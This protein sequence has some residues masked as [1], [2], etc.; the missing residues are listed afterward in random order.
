MQDNQ[1]QAVLVAYLS[2]IIDG[3]GWIIVR[4]NRGRG[5]FYF[6]VGV[7]M[8]SKHIIE[9]LQETFGGNVYEERVPNRRSIWRWK[10]L[11]QPN[12]LACLLQVR[13]Y[14]RVKHEQADVLIQEI[15][16]RL[17]R[18]ANHSLKLSDEELQRREDF[19]LR[20]KKLNAVGAAATTNREDTREGEVIV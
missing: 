14:L 13:P 15:T 18:T 1:K 17:A 16:L 7:G 11:N 4:K 19:Y 9:L 6:E 10:T 20:V 3:E 12:I 2:G 8:V 5:Q